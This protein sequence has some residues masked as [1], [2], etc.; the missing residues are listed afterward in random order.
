MWFVD[1]VLQYLKYTNDLRFVQDELWNTL[2]S[3]IENHMKGTAFNI[4]LEKDALL[5]HG[6]QLTWMDAAPNGIPVTPREGKAVEIQALWYNALETMQLLATCF[7][8]TDK[9]QEYSVLAEKARR[10]FNEV[11]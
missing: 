10:S 3:I 2:E 7:K 9:A 4:H 5:A 8:E 11:S 1:A 6:P